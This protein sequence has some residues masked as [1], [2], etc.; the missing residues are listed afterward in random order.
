VERRL[1][2]LNPSD[3]RRDHTLTLL[4][5]AARP[6][7]AARPQLLGREFV[8]AALLPIRVH[9]VVRLGDGE[10]ELEGHRQKTE[11]TAAAL[12]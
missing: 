3:T 12:D 5:K 6:L 8:V 4:A 7:H 1:P 11:H 9:V 2:S 10:E